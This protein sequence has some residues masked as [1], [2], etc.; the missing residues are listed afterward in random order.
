MDS[1]EGESCTSNLLEVLDYVGSLL[2][3]GKQ[4]DI[5]YM[6]MSKA[7]DKVNHGCLLQNLCRFGFRGSLLEWFS[8]YLMGGYQ[9]ATVLGE[10]SD[11]LP[12]RSG[13]P[14]G[15]ILGPM[16][17]LIHLINLPDSV[18]TS[19]VAM[20]NKLNI[21]SL[22]KILRTYKLTCLPAS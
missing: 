17:F 5:I 7:F 6:D 10:T 12:V 11:T 22:R 2:D 16:F 4:V 20:F 21:L 1:L 9:L 13:I 19:H 14:Q 18:L 15:S 3:D 8:S